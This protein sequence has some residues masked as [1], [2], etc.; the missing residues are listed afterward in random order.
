MATATKKK[1]AN[2]PLSTGGLSKPLKMVKMIQA[3][4]SVCSPR[5]QGPRGWW[6]ECPHEP[7]TSMQPVGP[8]PKKFVEQEDGTFTELLDEKGKPVYEPI[9]YVKRPN[10]KQ[11]ADDAKVTSGRMVRIQIERG[12][13]F[14]H[15][16]GFE[17]ICD[18]FNCWEK[19]PKVIARR[20]VNHEDVATIVGNYHNRD[21]AAIMTLRTT[22]TPIYVG[23]ASS[24]GAATSDIERLRQQLDAVNI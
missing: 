21:E 20:V 15:E 8:A 19:N 13:K 16:L 12:S 6:D 4:C 18:Y 5:G 3:R 17:P 7:Y 10:W 2:T 14:P 24:Y 1:T 23:T 9:R 11:V 22:G